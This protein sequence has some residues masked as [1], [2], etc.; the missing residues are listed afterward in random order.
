MWYCTLSDWSHSSPVQISSWPSRLCF[1]EWDG[2]RPCQIWRNRSSKTILVNSDH[3]FQ[4]LV[5]SKFYRIV[6]NCMDQSLG[7]RFWSK[8]KIGF[9]NPKNH[10]TEHP[11]EIELSAPGGG[12]RNPIV[13]A[14]T[15]P[16]HLD[17]TL[18]TLSFSQ[19][20]SVLRFCC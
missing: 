15:F 17:W 11:L 2:L 10:T 16:T 1:L 3:A 7:V 14:P 13:Q 8:V 18:M 12:D 19:F 20:V 4:S 9:I 5:I 6:D